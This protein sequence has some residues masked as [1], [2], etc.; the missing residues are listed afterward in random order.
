MHKFAKSHGTDL[1]IP[2]VIYHAGG[3][4]TKFWV[5]ET[6]DVAVQLEVRTPESVKRARVYVNDLVKAELTGIL[7]VTEAGENEFHAPA[8]RLRRLD[9]WFRRRETI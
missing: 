7:T 3:E 1:T 9:L 6:D 2:G 5:G 8:E 4:T